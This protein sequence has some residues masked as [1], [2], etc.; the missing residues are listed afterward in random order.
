MSPLMAAIAKGFA[1]A[2]IESM[3]KRGEMER[4]TQVGRLQV[5]KEMF[6]HFLKG[7]KHADEIDEKIFT[8][9][10]DLRGSM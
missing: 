6:D 10:D 4:M 1:G 2:A 5:E 8:S 9:L 3:L 7:L